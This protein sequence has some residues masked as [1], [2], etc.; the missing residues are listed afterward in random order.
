LY[1]DEHNFFFMNMETF[2]QFG[3]SS[4]S[5][6]EEKKFMKEDMIVFIL[7]YG[8]KPVG[9]N[10]PNFVEL[11][12]VETEPAIKGDTVSGATKTAVLET[13]HVI[14]VPLFV[15]Q[16]EVIKI[17]TRTGEYLERVK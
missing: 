12:I 6:E 11:Q 17:D 10:L 4:D 13:G 16:D 2:E 5:L 8:D 1:N 14:Q 15:N 9:I 3:L 7:M